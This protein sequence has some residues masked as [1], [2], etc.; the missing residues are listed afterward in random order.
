MAGRLLFCLA[1]TLVALLYALY[2]WG[3]RTWP[4]LKLDEL[5]FQMNASARGTNP[6]MIAEGVA[7]VL[8]PALLCLA[9]ALLA[10]RWLRRRQVKHR[11]LIYHAAAG[12]LLLALVPLLQKTWNRLEIGSYLMGED[13]SAQLLEEYYAD[14]GEVKLTFPEKK[15]NLIYI[16]LESMEITFAD[17]E[18]G[19]AFEQNVIPELT[20]LA[21]ENEDFS[22]AE[23]ALNGA[24]MP[25]GASWTMGAL[26][27]QTAGLPL[28]ISID[29]NAMNTQS[30]FF[31]ELVNLGDV[32]A[33]EGYRQAFLIGSDGNFAGRSLYFTQHGDYEILD[34]QHAVNSGR[35][36]PGY[37]VWW[38]Y[39]DERLFEYAREEVAALA[40]Q[41]EPF[42]LTLLTVD[43]HF[44]DG[45]VCARCDT[46]YG[47]SYANVYA[48][49]S[50]Q[51]SEFVAWLRQQDFYEDTVVVLAGDHLTMDS[52]FCA[53]IPEGYERR[54][55][56]AWLNTEKEYEGEAARRYTTFDCFPTTLSALGVS[57]EGDRLGLG[58]DLFSQEE[59]LVERYGMDWL[60]EKLKS[61]THILDPFGQVERVGDCALQ[62]EYA[63]EAAHFTVRDISGVE[64]AI[65]AVELEVQ[66][67]DGA[68]RQAVLAQQADGSYAADMELPELVNR[69]AQVRV[70]ALSEAGERFRLAEARGDLALYGQRDACEYVRLLAQ[71]EDYTLLLAVAD[72]ASNALPEEA[73]QLLGQM[74][75]KRLPTNCYRYAYCAVLGPDETRE[76]R[77]HIPVTLDGLLADG[78][79]YQLFSAGFDSGEGSCAV[80]LGET[81]YAL[82]QRG[83]NVVVYDHVHS[84]VADVAVFDE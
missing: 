12:V 52:D 40:A 3:F 59:T 55:Y 77:Q 11:A 29:G 38:G 48:C 6:E 23:Q 53:D 1:A 67:D 41:D 28:K 19:G 69:Y 22:G 58:V 70:Y 78:M 72:N 15:K 37:Y 34:Y 46:E 8:G 7:C 71:E 42:N 44:E 5:I 83:L 9:G 39:E 51:A 68:T 79:P 25:E 65:Q 45:Y 73:A 32:L 31:P 49:A 16:Y 84:R 75:L 62:I 17:Q 66:G 21:H 35:L 33:K 82:N 14:P 57:I 13:C 43:T 64:G 56:N 18:A 4:N 61:A 63:D 26:F 47:D 80:I 60:N 30:S 54:V 81:D 10:T 74:G 20:A 24:Y 27:A 50:R 36:S 76:E 2:G